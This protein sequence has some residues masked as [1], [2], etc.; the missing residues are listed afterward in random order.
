MCQLSKLRIW[1]AAPRF[2]GRGADECLDDAELAVF[3][4]LRSSQAK[5]SY[6]GAHVLLRFALTAFHPGTAPEDWRFART[7]T[8]RP[9]V[10][11]A[12]EPPCFSLSRTPRLVGCSVSARVPH[13]LDLV[14]LNQKVEPVEQIALS[15]E[16][17]AQLT[18]LPL[19]AKRER[20]AVLWALKEA[21][22]KAR[23]LGLTLPV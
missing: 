17:R 20:L 13:G 14:D 4:G 11:G 21:Y 9:V 16:E 15:R 6:L 12:P 8:G 1:L 5:A 18:D 2:A 22:V 3:E 10:I 19:A 23:G 7:G